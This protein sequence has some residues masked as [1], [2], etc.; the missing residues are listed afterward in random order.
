MEWP[1][2]HNW[3]FPI[4]RSGGGPFLKKAV[5]FIVPP[6]LGGDLREGEAEGGFIKFH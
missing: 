5:D 1:D 3:D 4:N 2:A 6:F